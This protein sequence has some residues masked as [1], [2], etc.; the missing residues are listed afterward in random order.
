MSTDDD[1][2]TART[3]HHRALVRHFADLRD[4]THGHDPASPQRTR[5]GKEQLFR[6]AV[7]LLDPY[8]RQALAEIDAELLLG[9]G[10]ITAT[11]VRPAPAGGLVAH[12]EL[13]WPEQRTTALDPIRLTAFYG[14]GFHHPHLQGGTVGQWPLN[15][16]TPRDAAAELP[17]LRAIAAAD[18]HNLVFRRDHR[19]IPATTRGA[20]QGTAQDATSDATRGAS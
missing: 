19:I 20:A 13:G 18:L 9:T 15:I 7:D 17:V 6:T 12:W 14:A 4:G 10:E 16:F 1:A 3:D 2:S 8:A 11:G 5:A